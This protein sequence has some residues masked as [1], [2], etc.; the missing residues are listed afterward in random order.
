MS[1]SKILMTG[2]HAATT[3]VAV[4]EEIKSQKKDWDVYWIGVKNAIEGR[5]MPTLESEVIPRLGAH[6]LPIIT[7]RLQRKFTNWTLL[8]IFKIPVGILQAIYYMVKIKPD[9]V[10]S[11]GGFA[12]FPVALAAKIFNV[13]FVIHEQTSV[14]G[15]ANRFCAKYAVE[16]AVSRKE[17]MKYFPS[18]K[19]RITGNPIMAA[20]RKLK[21]KTKPSLPP[22]IFITGG[23]RGSRSINEAIKP[24]LRT[25]LA[26][27]RVIHQTGGLDYL[28]FSE[29]KQQ[30]P[31]ALKENYELYLRIPPL[32]M[33]DIYRRAD[34]VVSRAGANTISELIA[35]RRP[36]ILVPLPISYLDEQTQNAK[37]A[38]KIGLAKIIVQK[39]LTSGK[40]SSAIEERLSNYSVITSRAGVGDNPDFDASRQIVGILESYIK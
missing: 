19:C 11:F 26:R 3:A 22:V 8:S 17:S 29:I 15:R 31:T 33:A 20:V 21:V 23:S 4:I 37:I 16:I 14:A 34:L 6:F 30:L 32:K 5:K 28:K 2:G 35:I 10:L 40:L 27:Y 18:G 24:I 38:E 25:L 13:P 12:S 36:A 1:T 7:G 9:V 39:D